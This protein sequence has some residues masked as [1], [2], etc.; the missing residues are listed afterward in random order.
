MQRKTVKR[1]TKS[2]TSLYKIGTHS[3]IYQL[4]RQQQKKE[5]K[6]KTKQKKKSS[7]KIKS[8]LINKANKQ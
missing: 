3:I 2:A 7:V 5:K 6:Q 4:Y 1:V 8:S